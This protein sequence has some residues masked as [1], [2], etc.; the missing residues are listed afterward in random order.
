MGVLKRLRGE[1]HPLLQAV[2]RASGFRAR[3]GD[4]LAM[5]R[6]VLETDLHVAT[7]GDVDQ[8][9]APA[10]GRLAADDGST[11]LAAFLDAGAVRRYF[12][13]AHGEVSMRGADL[14]REARANDDVALAVFADG[15]EPV[16]EIGWTELT[17]LGSGLLPNYQRDTGSHESL[18]DTDLVDACRQAVEGL[19]ESAGATLI[20]GIANDDIARA[21]L[22]VDL[23]S[24]V[25]QTEWIAV[26]TMVDHRL[27]ERGRSI[28]VV[29]SGDAIISDAENSKAAFDAFSVGDN[30]VPLR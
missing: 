15:G 11:V 20:E 9:G 19:P 13:E 7:G 21:T 12:S 25:S 29:L 14:C 2:S 26:R 4:V 5:W 23:D 30:E 18:R 27:A 16:L 3:A 1:R 10:I 28:P 22:M 17:W 6:T 24:G 8:S